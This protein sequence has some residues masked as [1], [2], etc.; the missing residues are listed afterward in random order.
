YT[1]LSLLFFGILIFLVPVVINE[2]GSLSTVY[3]EIT[4]FINPDVLSTDLAGASSLSDVIAKIQNT[5]VEKLF[6]SLGSLFGGIFNLIVVFV[7]SFYLSMQ[8]HGLDRVF[9]IFTPKKYE[10][11][12]RRVWKR[13]QTQIGGWFR[14]QLIIA[15]LLAVVT[16]IG[17]L[18]FGIPYALLLAL[19]AGLFGLVPYGIFIA[20][21]PAIGLGFIYGGLWKAFGVGVFYSM[22]QMLLDNVVQPLILNKIVGIPSL[23]VI[24]SMIIGAKLF[25]IAG[26]IIGIPL[27]LF[28][29]EIIAEIEK[30]K[31]ARAL[32]AE[33]LE[34][35]NQF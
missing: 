8:D 5:P 24:L 9:K 19:L 15:V 10:D 31:E 17:L 1:L 2:V 20:V 13:T 23:L 11:S 30:Y 12:I 34:S 33:D 4:Q 3:P 22:I 25:G 32:E 29:L 14:G 7:I 16:Y 6:S 21:I 27:A 28:G 35:E 18:L 26:L